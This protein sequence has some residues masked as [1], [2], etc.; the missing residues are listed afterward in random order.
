MTVHNNP[1][2]YRSFDDLIN[3]ENVPTLLNEK[4]NFL[5]KNGDK[6]T[7]KIIS[8]NLF[9]CFLRRIFG[10]YRDTHQNNVAKKLHESLY[11]ELIFDKKSTSVRKIVAV[12]K[13]I[14]DLSPPT[15]DVDVSKEMQSI[16]TQ[17]IVK[18]GDESKLEDTIKFLAKNRSTL[19]KLK[20]VGL[21]FT[22]KSKDKK[23]FKVRISDRKITLLTNKFLG[24]GGF[25]TVKTAY[26]YS[27]GTPLARAIITPKGFFENRSAKK[28][29]KF[30]KK[31]QERS[32]CVRLH[33]Y[34]KVKHPKR[35]IHILMDLAEGDLYQLTT[36]NFLTMKQ[37]LQITRQLLE[38]LADLTLNNIWHRDIKPRN[39]LYR[40]QPD[41]DTYKIM[42]ADFGLAASEGDLIAK[43]LSGGTRGYMPPEYHKVWKLSNGPI[44]DVYSLGVTLSELFGRNP[45]SPG[46]ITHLITKMKDS[47]HRTRITAVDA[48]DEYTDGLKLYLEALKR[49]QSRDL[50][51]L[52]RC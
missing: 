24:E 32:N 36:Q 34:H 21:L 16:P 50:K 44:G 8:L 7:W 12:A 25:K 31:V 49:R 40:Y 2:L 9:Q 22:L 41:D 1:N 13:I 23:L 47:N 45:S 5:K 20:D 15:E 11:S 29:L 6:D 4:G 35:K 39:I 48:F 10:F 52:S 38:A 28:E 17:E 37:K 51:P 30:L 14:K 42:V 43:K 26:D 19:E 46:F 18:N 27:Q 3:G 33:S